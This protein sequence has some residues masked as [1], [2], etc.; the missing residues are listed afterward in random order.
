[1]V[2]LRVLLGEAEA[3][4]RWLDERAPDAR[5]S[6]WRPLLALRALEHAKELVVLDVPRRR[7][8]DV[9]ARV[10]LAVIAG[11]HALRHRRDHVGR[12]DHG[13]PERMMAE[14][15][16]RE[17]IVNELLRCVLVHRD[18]LEYDGPF[19]VKVGKGRCERHVGHYVERRLHVGVGHA[20]V[21]HRVLARGCRVELAA[22]PVEDLRDLLSGVGARA[23]EEEVLDE[24]RDAGLGVGLVSGARPDPE[25]E[26][27]RADARNPLRDD[28]LARVELGEDV[29]LHAGIIAGRTGRT[30]RR[31]S[32]V[33]G[34]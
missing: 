18:L 27:D 19:R 12:P 6:R 11:E 13:A 29:L 30:P 7:D 22:E 1:V 23:L 25:A 16:L 15:R 33:R 10:H 24:V 31:S 14:D 9:A 20:R 26:R 5:P 8:H 28:P 34:R 32:G 17:E 21:D 3:G 4:R 2:L